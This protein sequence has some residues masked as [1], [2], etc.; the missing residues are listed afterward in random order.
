MGNGPFAPASDRA[1]LSL[2]S[3]ER[4][5]KIAE[6]K[7]FIRHDLA[8]GPQY[9]STLLEAAAERGIAEGT[10]YYAKRALGVESRRHGYGGQWSWRL[11]TAHH[12]QQQ[13]EVALVGITPVAARRPSS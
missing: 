5:R 12:G 7:A 6:A 1:F 9:A 10:L 8:D 4:R 2:T 11:R 3:A 13:E